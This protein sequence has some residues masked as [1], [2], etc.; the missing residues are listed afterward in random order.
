MKPTTESDKP[1]STDSNKKEPRGIKP[2][3]RQWLELNKH[4][5]SGKNDKD[6]I[7]RAIDH[8]INTEIPYGISRA[9]RSFESSKLSSKSQIGGGESLL[10]RFDVEE[11][12]KTF[13]DATYT[14]LSFGGP[15]PSEVQSDTSALKSKPDSPND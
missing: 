10:K 6:R 2:G 15:L 8:S 1:A 4:N 3:S 11:M 14:E 12:A 7:S 9:L 13:N 5:D